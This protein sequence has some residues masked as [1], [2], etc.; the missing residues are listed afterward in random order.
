VTTRRLVL[1]RHAKAAQDGLTDAQRPLAPRGD[2]DAPEVGRWLAARDLVPDRVVVSPS[3]RTRQTWDHA[4]GAFTQPP[5]A[6]ADPRLYDNTVDA[7]LRAL[8]DTPDD[9]RTV[10]LVGHNPSVQALA[11]TLDDG[12]GDAAARQELEGKYPTSAIAV[13]DVPGPWADLDEGAAT[14]V[15]FAAPRG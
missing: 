10:L 8:R 1:V 3:L 11:V 6:V 14:L 12:H 5:E 9:A 15:A 13:F 7:L 2:R 4:A